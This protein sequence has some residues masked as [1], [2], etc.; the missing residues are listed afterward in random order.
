FLANLK[1]AFTPNQSCGQG[2]DSLQ[3]TCVCTPPT[4]LSLYKERGYAGF[5][6]KQ[7]GCNCR[8]LLVTSAIITGVLLWGPHRSGPLLAGH[9]ETGQQQDLQDLLET[10]LLARRPVE[11]AFIKR[12]VQLVELD[13][14]PRNIVESTFLWARR[15]PGRPFPY[16]QTGLRIRAQRIGIK[17]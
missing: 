2:P 11:I 10:G 4:N 7:F 12:V 9:L 8:C 1:L 17:I 14:L 5:L 3:A 13:E 15:Q 16:F 6:M